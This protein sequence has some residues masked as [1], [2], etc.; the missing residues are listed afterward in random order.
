LPS[1]AVAA[2]IAAAVNSTFG[3]GYNNLTT[4]NKKK[5]TAMR[6]RMHQQNSQSREHVKLG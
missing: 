5:R 2:A 4:R 6:I 1:S 3:D